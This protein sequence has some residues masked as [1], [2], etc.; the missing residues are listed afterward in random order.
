[1]NSTA[2]VVLFTGSS[3]GDQFHANEHPSELQVPL[4]LEEEDEIDDREE[5]NG[6]NIPLESNDEGD[7]GDDDDEDEEEEEGYQFCFEEDMDPL[8]F[9]QVDASGLQPYQQFERLQ[10][11]Y[12]ALAAKKRKARANLLSNRD[13]PS[14]KPR[15]EDFSGAT[16]EEIMEAMNFGMGR[17]SRMA[18]KRGR[19]KGS[20]NKV[21]PEVTRKL[22]DATLHYAHGRYEEAIRLCSE[23]IRLSPNLP[24]SY[25]RLGLIYSQMGD[26][27]RALDFYMLAAHLTPKDVSLWK[28]L[29]TLSMELGDRGR[30]M[31]VLS[32]A[33]QAD[34]DDV[35]LRFH[36]A[37][38]YVELG[39][40]R[41]AAELY[42]QILRL[43]P[44]NLE[45]LQTATQ[46][47][48]KCGQHNRAIC[49]LEDFLEN[50]PNEV[51]LSVVNQL[52]S[53]CMEGNEHRKALEKIEHAE[54][55]YCAG[56][57]MPLYLTAKAGICHL[58]LGN[59]KKAEV[60]F[61]S[62]HQVTVHDLPN[63]IFEVGDALISHGHY[64]SAL[65]YYLMLERDS[66]EK[67]GYL[68]LKIA[69][70]Y[71]ALGK[72]KHSTECFYKA[73]DKLE[74]SVDARLTLSSLLLE[75]NKDNEAMSILSPPKELE[76]A[77]DSRSSAIKQW[78][79]NG[80]I[81]LKLS[82]IYKANGM[83]EEFVDVVFPVVRETL[84]LETVQQKV[85][86]KKRLTKRV[87]SERIK[88]V[89]EK[90]RDSVFHGFR[91]VASALDLSRASRAKKLLK[92]KVSVEEAKKAAAL[93]AG[94]EWISD[95][96]S[97][98]NSPHQVPKEPPLPDLLKDAEGHSLIMELC[99]GLSSFE[100]YWEALE[101]INLSL[102]LVSNTLYGEWKEELRTLGAQIAY[103][104]ADP[105][106]AW[107]YSRYVVSQ[108][109]YSSAAWNCYYKAMS[110]LDSRHSRHSKLLHAVR[111]K[112]KDAVPPI[113]ISGHQFTM[114]SQHQAAAREYLEAYKLMPD[115]PLINV[116]AATALINL[117]LGFRLQ[118]KHQ[119]LMQGL[120]FLYNNLRL[121]TNNQE[122]LYNIAR[123]Y[124]HVGLVSLAAA[125]YEKVLAMHVK[126]CAIPKLPNEN[127]DPMEGRNPGYCDL[128]RE[129]AFNLHL[130][131]KK[132]GALDLAR[133]VLKNHCSI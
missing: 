95:E 34:P 51:D 123:A 79:L 73:I 125:N 133:Q 81:K 47:Y 15:K 109:P 120:A 17:R 26:K 46:L 83:L 98:D 36:R 4:P 110:K 111:T 117:A 92:K 122:A 72:R 87:L 70:C 64:D 106:R 130:I 49:V 32:K 8:S 104:I 12:E 11:Q 35:D 121:C 6:S 14:K 62:L 7:D 85:K 13:S 96:D 44:N 21:S 75:E 63:L 57:E 48:K 114:I 9:T 101:I 82:Q 118:N 80:K 78:W 2:G 54:R 68:H 86:V 126:D 132:S 19:R 25:H 45:V 33:I 100:R 77:V 40:Y 43:H 58:H 131:Y 76:T 1:M 28:V 112:H 60:L 93:A 108:R 10:H 89:D 30:S 65:K 107:E 119:C 115:S 59:V 94:V 55:V 90:Q 50:H 66:N 38:L 18:K 69:Q 84:F 41:K 5:N 124:H 56:K 61:S 103:N 102:K 97:D 42:E 116:C 88:V 91:P 129:A 22:G 74:N 105:A 71:L 20:K 24:D 31:Y 16:F 39:D 3:S 67:S 29:V 99:K 37:S 23:V 53:L 128:R 27:K 52:A 113:L 127:P